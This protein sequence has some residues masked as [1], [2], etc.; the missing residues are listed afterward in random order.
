MEF[1]EFCEYMEKLESTSSKLE[2]AR[3]LSELYAGADSLPETISLSYGKM[4]DELGVAEALII[5]A[6]SRAYGI[7]ESDIKKRFRKLGDLGLVAESL[8]SSRTQST[9]MEKSFSVRDIYER[10]S[11]LPKMS[12]HGAMDRKLELIVELLTHLNGKAA[13]YLVRILLS[14]LRI[15]VGDGTVRDALAMAFSI[16]AEKI[17]RAYNFLPDYA[18]IGKL[19]KQGKLDQVKVTPGIPVRVML[20]EASKLEEAVKKLNRPIAEYKYDGFRVQIHKWKGGLKIFTRRLEDVTS[21]FPEI[22]EWAS[23]IPHEYIMEGEAVAYRNGFLPFQYISRRIQR[24]Y[25][26]KDMAKE[27]PVRVF[28]FDLLWMDGKDMIDESLEKR[29]NTLMKMIKKSRFDFA[30]WTSSDFESFYQKALEDKQEGIMLKDLDSKY[31]AGKRVGYWYKIK[32]EK[33]TLDVVITAAEYGEGKKAGL[34]SSFVIAVRNEWGD[35]SDIGKVSSGFS[36]EELKE[37]NEMIKDHIIDE[38]DG[39]AVVRPSFVIEVRFQEIQRSP[40]YPSGFALRFP[41]FVRFRPD[42]SPDSADTLERVA[43]LFSKQYK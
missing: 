10:L 21:R 11:L 17:E 29:R 39:I 1:N 37:I 23:E 22:R 3:I 7:S 27:I 36:D 38:R 25:G 35:F 40:H 15:G 33:E 24:K 42:R 9:L 13:K 4:S 43:K 16:P 2:K 20:A 18:M 31:I 30:H 8:S 28:L 34:F 32:P 26:I 19:I 14:T 12:G 6:M 41:R 5:K